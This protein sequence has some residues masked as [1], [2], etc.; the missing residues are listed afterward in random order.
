MHA[1]HHMPAEAGAPYGPPLER[2]GHNRGKAT[3]ALIATWYGS[4]SRQFIAL[5]LAG[6]TMLV[7]YRLQEG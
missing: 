5:R 3:N 4:N 6:E 2:H 1:S 7:F